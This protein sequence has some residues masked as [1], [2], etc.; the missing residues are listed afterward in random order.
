VLGVALF[1]VFGILAGVL[2][3]WLRLASGSVWPPTVAHAALNAIA[4][5]PLVLLR[6]VDP[7]VAGVLYSPVGWLVLLAAIGLLVRSGALGRALATERQA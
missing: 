1:V 5:L 4:G 2:L 7:A 3:G 6:G